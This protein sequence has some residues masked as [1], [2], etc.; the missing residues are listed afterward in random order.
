M[1]SKVYIYVLLLLLPNFILGQSCSIVSGL[2]DVSD[3]MK[4]LGNIPVK[5]GMINRERNIW[6][7]QTFGDKIYIGYGNTTTNPGPIQLYSWDTVAEA[8]NPEILVESEAIERFRVLNGQLIVPNSDPTS[9]DRKKY[10]YLENDTWQEFSDDFALAHVRDIYYYNS[11]Y[12]LIGNS[13]C[14]D[15]YSNACSGMIKQANL[16]DP[17]DSSLLNAELTKADPYT[18]SLWNWFFGFLE[19]DGKLVIPNAMF[20][21]AY[22]PFLVIKHG[23]FFV[24]DQNSVQWS[25]NMSANER[26]TLPNIY[27]VDTTV[28]TLDTLISKI[29]LTPFEQVEFNGDYLY[30]MR[31]YS[32]HDV[33][34]KAAY[35][36][37]KGMLFKEDLMSNA[38]FVNFPDVG[39]IGEDLL[40]ENGTVY[41]LSNL[42][43]DPDNY[44]VFVYKSTNPSELSSS[45][46]MVMYFDSPNR[47]RSFEFHDGKFY[48]GLGN[49][50]NET[51]ANAGSLLSV[52]A[53]GPSN[54]PSEGTPCDDFDPCTTNDAYDQFC[55]CQGI[56]L[57]SDSDGI[58]DFLEECPNHLNI[59]LDQQF[60]KLYE[61]SQTI[62]F[63]SNVNLMSM[64]ILHSDTIRFLNG[65][66]ISEN[67]NMEAIIQACMQ[68]RKSN[69]FSSN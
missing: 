49:N 30:T 23:E 31:S 48:F 46:E 34:Y 69:R 59:A 7:L 47:A 41:A 19:F 40:I 14:P 10:Y 13:R 45:W 22:N 20:S 39:S 8:F 18:N 21:A 52:S 61:S 51:L 29:I 55:S 63:Q 43:I 57:D 9:G 3:K 36:N 42:K 26:I 24:V 33:L 25:A 15:Q 27:P 2:G 11:E 12:Y 32:V 62:N 67:S 50:H 28:T 53:C 65:T 64:I 16:T 54:C 38:K 5:E 17:F 68:S 6:D 56:Y 58:C 66:N 35:K 44:R 1:K 60:D 37:S 4:V